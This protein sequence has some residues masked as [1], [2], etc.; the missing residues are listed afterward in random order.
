MLLRLAVALFAS[1][2]TL[3]TAC[4]DTKWTLPLSPFKP[5]M[6]LSQDIPEE[7]YARVV[8]ETFKSPA[9]LFKRRI[10]PESR[11]NVFFPEQEVLVLYPERIVINVRAEQLFDSVPSCLHARKEAAHLIGAAYGFAITD[12]A[13]QRNGDIEISL[14]C[15]LR[16]NGLALTLLARS[17]SAT[18]K[19]L[20]RS[21]PV[22]GARQ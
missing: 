8:A 2:L 17:V 19:W 21:R 7:K 22:R 10:A 14:D 16:D 20:S 5:G 1:A 3:S 6:P 13:L 18:D 4:A 12:G 15:L 11:Q 9:E